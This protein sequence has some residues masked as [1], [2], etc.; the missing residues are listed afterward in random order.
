MQTRDMALYP[1]GLGL[2]TI[3]YALVTVQFLW[4]PI[5]PSTVLTSKLLINFCVRFRKK[6]N[7]C[8]D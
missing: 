3:L 6:N 1:E 4:G 5:E 7:K 2:F 8:D